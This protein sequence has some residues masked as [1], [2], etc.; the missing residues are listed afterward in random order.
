MGA[1]RATR[2]VV[3]ADDL[4]LHPDIDA[5]ILRA[6]REGVVTSATVLATGPSAPQALAAARAQGLPVGVH[7][8][9]TTRLPPAAAPAQVPSVAPGGRFRASW[10]QL[11]AAWAAG[12]VRLSE[13]A[14]ELSAQVLR[15][16]AL[17]AEVDHLDAHQHLH[18]L[19]GIA[20]VV[21]ALAEREALPLRWPQERPRLG[22]LRTPGPALKTALLSGLAHAF[23]PGAARLPGVG[24]FEAG[25]LDEA[26]LLALLDRLPAGDWEL[27]CHPGARRVEVPED[28]RWVYGWEAELAALTSPRVRARLAARGITLTSYRELFPSPGPAA[29]RARTSRC[30]EV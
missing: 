24:L 23:P 12:R 30:G 21:H 5:G 29:F 7:L 17:G 20:R 11:T 26:T 25:R 4:G 28:P 9:L 13:V 27:S 18:L 2:L 15:A 16:R 22:W 19:P 3:N 10:V 6:H 8:C 1:A 14:E